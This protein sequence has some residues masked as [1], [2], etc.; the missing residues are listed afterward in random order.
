MNKD[1]FSYAEAYTD[2]LKYCSEKEHKNIDALV[3]IFRLNGIEKDFRTK[4]ETGMRISSAE[5]YKRI[6]G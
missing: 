1:K 6:K 4:Y 2:F 3:E 5:Y